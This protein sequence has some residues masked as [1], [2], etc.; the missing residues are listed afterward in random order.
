MRINDRRGPGIVAISAVSA[1]G[2]GEDAARAA[3]TKQKN[4]QAQREI[5]EKMADERRG[6]FIMEYLSTTCE[7]HDKPKKK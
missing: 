2:F 3:G 5:T 4:E 1:G 7:L 6:N